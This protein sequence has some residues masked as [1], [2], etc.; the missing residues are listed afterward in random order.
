MK[1]WY[2]RYRDH[3]GKLKTVPGFSD[4]T[5]TQQLAGKLE[6]EASMIRAGLLEPAVLFQSVSLQSHLE[7]F[8]ASLMAKDVSHL[9]VQLVVNRCRR[10]LETAKITRLSGVNSELIS[11]TLAAMRATKADGQRGLSVQTSNHYLLAI[12]QLTR[13]LRLEKRFIDDPLARLEMLNVQ[14]DRRHDR[15]ALSGDEVS[16]L[17]SCT[18]AGDVVLG[19]EPVDRHMLYVMAMSTGL[20]ASELASLTPESLQLDASPPTV[21]VQAGYSK[22]R[23]LD[24]LPLPTDILEIAG[25]W[26]ATKSDDMR[27]W[28]GNWAS[29]RA[30]GKILQVDLKAA[31]IPY[32]DAKGL[33]ADFH[34]LRHTYITNLARNGVPLATAQKLA[35]HS[36]PVLTAQRYTHIDL[37]DQKLA[38]DRLPSMQKELQRPL[39]RADDFSCQNVARDGNAGESESDEKSPA[40]PEKNKGNARLLKRR[41][42]DSNSRCPFGHTGFRDRRIRPLCHLSGFPSGGS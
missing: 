16:K 18:L 31:G 4:K 7:A 41:R 17:L 27:L 29:R 40:K 1:K 37:N 13:W 12:K 28:P 10:L 6:R 23:R 36:T 39:Q 22:R 26:L 35:R 2:I 5:A 33:F 14:V 32:Q 21:T 8:E 24:V 42:R 9:Q 30:G 34:A 3:E 38:V 11:S 25:N 19:F 15:R 20:R